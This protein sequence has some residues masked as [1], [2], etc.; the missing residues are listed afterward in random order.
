MHSPLPDSSAL[1]AGIIADEN[2]P[3]PS[4]VQD[5]VRNLLRNSVLSSIR[6][7]AFILPTR[8]ACHPAQRDLGPMAPSPL[9]PHHNLEPEVGP[10]PSSETSSSDASS[11]GSS[12]AEHNHIPGVLFPPYSYTNALQQMTHQ[13]TLFNTRAVAALEHPDLSDPS[14]ALF[15]QQK[16]E[17]RQQRAWKRSRHGGSSHHHHRKSRKQNSS[18]WWMCVISALLLAAIIATYLALATT[19]K[20]LSTTFHI[21]FILGI[22]FSTIVFAHTVIRICLFNRGLAGTAPFLIVPPPRHRSR[23]HPR[24][25]HRRSHRRPQIL[26]RPKSMDCEDEFVPSV[27]IP[28]CVP[29]EDEVRP[30]SREAQPTGG[31]IRPIDGWD[32]DVEAL[33]NPPPAYGRWRGSVRA[34]PD[35]LHWA[36]SPT[37]PRTPSL[38][39]PTYEEAMEGALTGNSVPPSYKTKESPARPIIV[40]EVRETAAPAPA[41]EPEMVEGRGIGIAQ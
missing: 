21:L 1:E 32:K 14:L 9:R 6:G 30:D 2:A 18:Q 37:T 27:P 26:E 31:T 11:P 40:E 23:G 4:R 41:A 39:S 15:L 7:S 20:S 13:S 19:Q 28:V 29:A 3:R 36:P 22:L 16:S 34:N 24:Q 35:L 12:T 38:P 25:H 17:S 8:N 10:S 33:P 5:N